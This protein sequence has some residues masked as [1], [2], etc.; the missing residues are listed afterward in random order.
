MATRKPLKV[1][2][3]DRVCSGY[4]YTS[5][6]RRSARDYGYYCSNESS[7]GMVCAWGHEPTQWSEP[8]RSIPRLR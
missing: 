5:C 2:D 6:T 8:F 1:C 7:V 3:S 4:L